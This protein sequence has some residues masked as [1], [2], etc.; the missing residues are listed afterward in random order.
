MNLKETKK[1]GSNVLNVKITPNITK[2][3]N[4]S[5]K[6]NSDTTE[7]SNNMPKLLKANLN[8]KIMYNVI[9][10]YKNTIDNTKSGPNLEKEKG[11]EGCSKIDIK[12]SVNYSD[13][14]EKTKKSN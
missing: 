5:K 6:I 3:R 9:E 1:Y 12:I 4:S 14:I 13:K 10:S 2:G 11:G 8:D 7:H